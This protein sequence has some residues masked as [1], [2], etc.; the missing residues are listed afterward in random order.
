MVAG[1]PTLRITDE[2]A[3][4]TWEKRRIEKEEQQP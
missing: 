3:R 2:T 4:E 1:S